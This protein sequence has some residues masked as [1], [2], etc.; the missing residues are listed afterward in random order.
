MANVGSDLTTGPVSHCA[1]GG[2]ELGETTF[3][4]KSGDAVISA[5]RSM[6]YPDVLGVFCVLCSLFCV[7]CSVFHVLC[8]MHCALCSVLCSLFCAQCPISHPD[9]LCSVCSVL[10]VLT[11]PNIAS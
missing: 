9:V 6:L 7:L 11:V 2:V 3:G 5:R 1:I 10:T 8:S 4:E